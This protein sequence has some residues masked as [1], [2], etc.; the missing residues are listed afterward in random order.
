MNAREEGDAVWTSGSRASFT[1][2][3]G[4]HLE[5]W[6]LSAQRGSSDVRINQA[7]NKKKLNREIILLICTA[8]FI[9]T[10]RMTHFT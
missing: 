5:V 7:D 6:V 8:V 10:F 4:V 9:H 1:H 2:L 3:S